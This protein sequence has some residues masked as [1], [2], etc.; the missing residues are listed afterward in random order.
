M[1]PKS[2]NQFS[3]KIMGKQ[4]AKAKSRLDFEWFRLSFVTAHCSPECTARP[5]ASGPRV[6]HG[7]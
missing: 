7:A 6:R 2:G 5:A 3:D 4:K 1:I